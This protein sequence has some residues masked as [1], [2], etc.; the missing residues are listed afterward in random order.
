MDESSGDDLNPFTSPPRPLAGADMSALVPYYPNSLGGW[1]F[2]GFAAFVLVSIALVIARPGLLPMSSTA[3]VTVVAYATLLAV[4][5]ALRSVR[6]GGRALGLLSLTLLTSVLVVFALGGAVWVTDDTTADGGGLA[7]GVTVAVILA[8]SAAAIA[9]VEVRRARSLRYERARQLIRDAAAA[10]QRW[11]DLLAALH[12]VPASE[13]RQAQVVRPGRILPVPGWAVVDRT[14]VA[15]AV[16]SDS[17]RG[18]WIDAVAALA[19]Q[20]PGPTPQRG[21][22]DAR[23]V[24]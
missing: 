4:T 19:A 17:D 13:L 23:S 6:R 18:A 2:L 22:A 24:G 3:F 10:A 14:G 1:L 21:P 16:A 11:N 5:L 8:C 7:R 9:F 20:S 12:Q 15:L